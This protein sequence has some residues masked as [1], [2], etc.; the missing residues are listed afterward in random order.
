MP[1][2]PS[3]IPRA[4]R[5]LVIPSRTKKLQTPALNVRVITRDRPARRSLRGKR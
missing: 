5:Y 4:N 3:S 1:A 2:S